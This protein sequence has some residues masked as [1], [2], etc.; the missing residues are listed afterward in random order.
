MNLEGARVKHSSFAKRWIVLGFLLFVMPAGAFAGTE[1]TGVIGG[2]IGGDLNSVI[3]S[4]NVSISRSFN[5]APVYGVRVGYNIPFVQLEGSF[6]AS[7]HGLSLTLQ[8]L[9]VS[10]DAKVYYLEANA[11]FVP[12][13][14]LISPFFTAGVGLHHYA[15]A[16]SVADF[17]ALD[18]SISKVGYNF[19]GGVKINISQLVI[20]GE[21][22]DHITK[23]GPED[24]GAGD[25]AHELGFDVQEKLHN[26]EIS[27]GVGIRF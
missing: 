9:P 14:G 18:T 10:V 5:N 25:I 2:L 4:N 15:F 3:T 7:P 19:G 6:V 27:V 12:I 24:F 17:A 1:I 21:V 11:L 22:R 16:L 13:P 26:V 23:I 8:N 20:R